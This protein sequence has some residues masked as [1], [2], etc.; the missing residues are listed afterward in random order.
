[1]NKLLIGSAMAALLGAMAPAFAQTAPPAGV[2]P[3]TSTNAIVRPAPPQ[4]HM[5]MRM[6]SN[7]VMTRAEVATHVQA[8][9][10]RLDTNHDGFITRDEVQAVRQKMMAMHAGMERNTAGQ[11]MNGSG[12]DRGAMFDQLDTNHDGSISRQEYMAGRPQIR[13]RRMIVMRDGKGADAMGAQGMGAQGMGQGQMHGMG[14]HGMG[15]HG[16]GMGGSGGRMFDMADT[17]HDGRISLAEAQ[18]AALAQFDRADLNHDGQLTPDERKQAHAM[19][20][21]HH[22]AS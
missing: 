12:P 19:M 20:R 1:M 5:R 2:A 15:Q 10:A 17:N 3:G 13:E 6:M 8:M 9:F 7:K 11:G 18:A 14:G 21:G 22:P 4:Q 16:M